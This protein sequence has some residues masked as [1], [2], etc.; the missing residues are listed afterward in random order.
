MVKI[1]CPKCKSRS[2]HVALGR[3]LW[4]P[5]PDEILV[6]ATCGTRVYGRERVE[7]L[8]QAV[9]AALLAE[10]ER[11]QEERRAF[12]R[13]LEAERRERAA[14]EKAAAEAAAAEAARKK[15]LARAAALEAEILQNAKCAWLSC[16]ND[17]TMTS[18]YCSRTC[19]DRNAHARAKERRLAAKPTQAAS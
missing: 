14:G 2:T 19:S 4:L 15:R 16:E 7:P 13:A 8:R 12:E 1:P 11:K 10:E 5:E 6:C 17:H 9:M 18:K 3:H